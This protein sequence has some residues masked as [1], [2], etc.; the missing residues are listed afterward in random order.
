MWQDI[1]AE[2]FR[3]DAG[4]LWNKLELVE[5]AGCHLW[6]QNSYGHHAP[7][8]GAVHGFAGNAF[9]VIPGLAPALRLR[10]IT[11]G[12]PA[13]RIAP[14]DSPHGKTTVRPGRNRSAGIVLV[15]VSDWYSIV[16]AHLA[17]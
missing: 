14:S 1:W 12:G 5:E 10:T 16:T 9:A 11:L 6:V 8:I 17:S 15:Y 3:R 7:H 2:R 4:L 13:G